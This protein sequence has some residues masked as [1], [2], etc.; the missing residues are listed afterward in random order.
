M[1]T[2]GN[3]RYLQYILLLG[4]GS[5]LVL[6]GFIKKEEQ[7]SGQ[8]LSSLLLSNS[9]QLRQQIKNDKQYEHLFPPAGSVNVDLDTFD[10]SLLTL[11]ILI[12]F[13]PNLSS[14]DRIAVRTIRTFRNSLFG[15]T[16]SLSLEE[17]DFN[18][19]RQDLAAV[20]LQLARELDRDIYDQCQ[21]IIKRSASASFEMKSVLQELKNIHEFDVKTLTRI[22]TSL[23]AAHEKLDILCREK[24]CDEESL[25]HPPSSPELKEMQEDTNEIRIGTQEMKESLKEIKDCLTNSPSSPELKEMQRDT[26]QIKITTQEMKESFKDIKEIKELLLKVMAAEQN[27]SSSDTSTIEQDVDTKMYV[28]GDT[29]ERTARAEEEIVATINNLLKEIDSAGGYQCIDEE[30]IRST[31]RTLL[32]DKQGSDYELSIALLELLRDIIRQPGTYVLPAVRSCVVLKIRCTSL[33]SLLALLQYLESDAFYQRLAKLSAVVSIRLGKSMSVSAQVAPDSLQNITSLVS[34]YCAKTCSKVITLPIRCRSLDALSH[35]WG[36]FGEGTAS[37]H[38]S[39]ISESIT[40][41]VG[42]KITVSASVNRSQLKDQLSAS[43]EGMES[44]SNDKLQI[45]KSVGETGHD[46][47]NTVSPAIDLPTDNQEVQAPPEIPLRNVYKIQRQVMGT[48]R[49]ESEHTKC[50]ITC[51]CVLPNSELLLGDGKHKKLKKLNSSYE[52]TSFCNVKGYPSDVCYLGH[53]EA[54]V[55]LSRKVMQFVDVGDKVTPTRRVTLEHICTGMASDG[56]LI[57]ITDDCTLYCYQRDLNEHQIVFK[58]DG[59]NFHSVAVNAMEERIFYICCNEKLLTVDQRG[60]IVNSL[61]GNEFSDPKGFCFSKS[62]TLFLGCLSPNRVLCIDVNEN[63][64]MGTALDDLKLV[65][66]ICF[67]TEKSALIIGAC[68]DVITVYEIERLERPTKY[69]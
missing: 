4:E 53:N 28:T 13:G 68:D 44:D 59:N 58:D 43:L 10:I 17:D 48:I 63:R 66:S 61:I 2:A 1:T 60:Q 35:V 41:V 49:L 62:G 57:Y 5:L 16:T 11:I 3:E 25:T 56:S 7:K 26:H 30:Q 15:H 23:C 20:L 55:C 12:L 31:V 51:C 67:D 36:M 54:V 47:E 38:F 14:Q 45:G 19:H 37:H 65:R 64:I 24:S 46:T 52:L 69:I 34:K 40:N 50:H 32:R 39:R 9:K 18:M 8:T 33:R 27:G 6:K 21:E 42:G 29:D 22:E